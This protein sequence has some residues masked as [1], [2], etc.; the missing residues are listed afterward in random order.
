MRPSGFGGLF[1]RA[2]TPA[3]VVERLEAACQEALRDPFYKQAAERQYL[4]SDYLGRAVF[5]AR[6]NEEYESKARLLRSLD[7]LD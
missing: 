1:V 2:D 5:T 7:L 6:V 4:T 3:P